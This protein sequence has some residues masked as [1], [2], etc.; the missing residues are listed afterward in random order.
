MAGRRRFGRVR[1][2]PSGRWQARYAGPDGR[3]HPASATFATKTAAARWLAAVET[4]LSRSLWLDP[5]RGAVSFG[6]YA[7]EWLAGRGDLKLRTQELYR[8]LLGK[9]LLPALAPV[10]LNRLSPG[11]VRAWHAAAVRSGSPSPTAQAYGLL[12]AILNTAVRDEVLLRN[13]CML[14]G[15]GSYRPAERTVASLAQ[16]DAVANAVLPRYRAFILLAA[17]SG[18]R[19]GELV[20]L[21]RDRLDLEYGAITIDSQLIELRGHGVLVPESP[22]TAAGRRRVHIPPHLLPE[23]AEHLDTYVPAGCRWVLPNAKGEPIRRSSFQST[24]LKAREQ[25][26]VPQLRFHDLRHTGNTLAAATG[27]STRELMARMGHSSMGAALIYQHATTERDAAI[28]QA[29]S[30][31]AAAGEAALPGVVLRPSGRA[32]VLD[33]GRSAP[34]SLR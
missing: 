25:A 29:L 31:F 3:D 23:L 2:L 21:T 6:S 28:A 34:A 26:G 18:A 13:P 30:A 20:A 16:I 19:W 17:W 14:R 27:A 11:M 10:P 15:A 1:Q 12:R 32:R 22:K 24:W 5:A 9:Y 4:D 7:T 8:W 33:S